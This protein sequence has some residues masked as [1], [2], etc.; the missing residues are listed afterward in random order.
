LLAEAES[1]WH[2]TVNGLHNMPIGMQWYGPDVML[3]PELP[4]LTAHVVPMATGH[5]SPTRGLPDTAGRAGAAP[6]G[7]PVTEPD[8]SDTAAPGHPE[9]QAVP[10]IA[11]FMAPLASGELDFQQMVAQVILAQG[12][13]ATADIVGCGYVLQELLPRILEERTST[14]VHWAQFLMD[15]LCRGHLPST[16]AERINAM[17]AVF[18]PLESIIASLRA[19]SLDNETVARELRAFEEEHLTII[20]DL[21]T[22]TN[23]DIKCACI[24]CLLYN[25]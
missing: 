14:Q 20:E 2:P 1:I 9:S 8:P 5:C 10:A 16:M 12:N 13:P 23:Y 22:R 24:V 11:A 18:P 4:P 25:V 21:G 15:R 7:R 3:S 6:L 19:L 17:I